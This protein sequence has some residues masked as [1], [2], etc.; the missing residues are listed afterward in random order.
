MDHCTIGQQLKG[1]CIKRRRRADQSL[2]I[3]TCSSGKEI[4]HMER[5]R[6]STNVLFASL[7]LPP[8][9]DM[10][11]TPTL[12]RGKSCTCILIRQGRGDSAVEKETF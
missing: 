6:L 8:A 4:V 7:P 12:G 3:R 1:F 11:S 9:S 2:H 10:L 5:R